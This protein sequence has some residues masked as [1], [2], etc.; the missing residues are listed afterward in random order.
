MVMLTLTAGA[1]MTN[2]SIDTTLD[3]IPEPGTLAIF[4][5]GLVGL[6]FARR[7]KAA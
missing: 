5:L 7:K 3:V 2:G 1:G 6:G 4:G